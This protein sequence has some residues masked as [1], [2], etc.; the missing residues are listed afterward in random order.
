MN[1]NQIFFY[2]T[3]LMTPNASES[4]GVFVDVH[5][6]AHRLAMLFERSPIFDKNNIFAIF[7]I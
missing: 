3:Q 5:T 7:V 2:I 6:D 4:Q 1:E